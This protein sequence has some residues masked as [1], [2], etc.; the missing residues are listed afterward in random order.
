M[1]SS[2]LNGHWQTLIDFVESNQ[3]NWPAEPD[4]QVA[5]SSANESLLTDS[6]QPWGI[7]LLDTPPHNRLLGPVFVR[8]N[9]CGVIRL[10][11]N[12]VCQW[13]DTH[14]AD[15][16]FSVTKTC[17]ALVA[18][19][20]WDQGLLKD[21]D[22]PIAGQLP[23]IGFDDEHNRQ[24]TWRHMLNF[25]SEWQGEC[26]GV[27]DQVDRYRTVGLQPTSSVTNHN[28][29]DPRPLKTPG[30]Y[31]EYN[32][33]RIN[34][35]SKALLHLFKQP[36]P[37]LLKKHFMDPV[38][39][40][41]SWRWHGYDNSWVDIDGTSMQSVPGG[42][43]WGGGLCISADDQ[44]RLAE[45][46]VNFGCLETQGQKQQLVS[47][48]WIDMMLQPCPI[49]P[50][51]GFFTWLNTHHGISQRAPESCFFAMGIGGQLLL[52]D[53][54]NKLVGIFRWIDSD[55]TQ[56]IVDLTYELLQSHKA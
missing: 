27:P 53:P 37:E 28:K 20:A 40:S 49:A 25:T 43:H 22:Q 5:D 29:G 16:T 55:K 6:T 7:H 2:N 9:T 11:N 15:M 39:A 32:D 34:Q 41:D 42:G 21:L 23:G 47:R 19:V 4:L 51:Y 33:I 56:S 52:H 10:N 44:S 24:I 13:G 35:F 38:G 17:L 54:E 48:D 26:F 30:S 14:R 1:S 45:L 12:T 8:G 50:F 46:L 36:L 3:C 31:W 18:G